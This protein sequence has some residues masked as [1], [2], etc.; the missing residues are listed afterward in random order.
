MGG[1]LRLLTLG[2]VTISLR[3]VPNRRTSGNKK[4][5]PRKRCVDGLV[6][7][8]QVKKAR[9]TGSHL[10]LFL[11]LVS[12]RDDIVTVH[13]HD[14]VNGNPLRAGFLTLTEQCASTEALKIHL[15]DHLERTAIPLRLP[16]GQMAKVRDLRSG[17]ERG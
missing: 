2:V 9:S 14:R 15:G 10:Y 4:S 1:N 17:E 12:G 13:L 3:A 6:P 8:W 16:L 11:A 5:R 7:L